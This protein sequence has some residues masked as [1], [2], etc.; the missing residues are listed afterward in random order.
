LN[1][2]LTIHYRF[3]LWPGE[4]AWRLKVELSRHANFAPDELWT[5]RDLSLSET[6]LSH[7]LT[8]Q[9]TLQGTVAQLQ[10]LVPSLEQGSVHTLFLSVSPHREGFRFT[11]V[12]ATDDLGRTVSFSGHG[13]NGINHT[14]DFRPAPDAK[15]LNVTFALHPSRFVE[16]TVKPEM[17]PAP[18]PEKDTAEPTR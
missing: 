15:S 6:N 10:R 9:T 7:L 3:G 1:G 5:V 8:S 2:Q 13:G 18:H 16:F 17:G 14:I 4:A 12:E 11:I